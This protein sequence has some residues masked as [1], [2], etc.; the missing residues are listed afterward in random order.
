MYSEILSARND[1]LRVFLVDDEQD[2]T[3]IMSL[4]LQ[5]QGCEV[6]TFNDARKALVN[7]KPN[8]YDSIILDVRM[9]NMS[10]FEL[11]KAIW[12]RDA[13]ARICFFSAFEIYESE[14]RLVFRDFKTHCFIKKPI[15]PSALV[16]HIQAHSMPAE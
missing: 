5:K 1:K 15:T 10:G 9:P 2:I 12:A 7:F 11:A 16:E 14:A 13:T 4:G 3:T 6:E 8:Y